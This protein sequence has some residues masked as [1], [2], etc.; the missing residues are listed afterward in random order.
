MRYLHSPV[1]S[2]NMRTAVKDDGVTLDESLFLFFFL[3]LSLSFF[4]KMC[5]ETSLYIY[6]LP[7]ENHCGDYEW[8]K[9]T[10]THSFS[11]IKQTSF[12]FKHSLSCPKRRRMPFH[13]R[14]M[15]KTNN[16]SGTDIRHHNPFFFFQIN[17]TVE[18]C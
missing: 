2:F 16:S 9:S 7:T 18:S 14:Y 1:P 17:L 11:I 4:F 13:T 3:S 6:K 5:C 10:G 15:F 8:C 12:D